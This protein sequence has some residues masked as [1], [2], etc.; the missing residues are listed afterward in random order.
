MTNMEFVN[1][2]SSNIGRVAYKDNNLYVEYKSGNMYKYLDVPK[3]TYTKLV[4]SESKGRFM[5]SYI[6]EQFK[7]EKV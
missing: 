5:N 2:E 6:K 7:Y 4:E 3:E 1:V